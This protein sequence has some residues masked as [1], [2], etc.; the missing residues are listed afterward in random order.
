VIGALWTTLRGVVAPWLSA[1]WLRIL[2]PV[3][4]VALV[5][6][7]GWRVHTWHESHRQLG[8]VQDALQ[9]ERDCV[10][11][12]A[13]ADRLAQLRTAGIAAVETA[14]R[15]AQ[16]RASAAQAKRD[17]EVG[18]EVERLTAAASEARVKAEAWRRKYEASLATAACATWSRT[19]VPCAISD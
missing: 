9:A 13:C 14:R 1:T 15:T 17:A 6:L 10:A 11:G 4:G 16:E 12:T 8:V 3:A 19:E 18:A 5:A 7:A 2:I